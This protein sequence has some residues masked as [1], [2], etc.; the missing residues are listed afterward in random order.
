MALPE[1]H[2]YEF[3]LMAGEKIRL[4]PDGSFYIGDKICVGNAFMGAHLC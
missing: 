3:R 2:A 4:E 1:E